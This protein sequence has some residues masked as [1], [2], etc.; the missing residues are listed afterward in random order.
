MSSS[1]II[2]AGELGA[3]S[4]WQPLSLATAEAAVPVPAV[5]EPPAEEVTPGV[6]GDMA[7][8]V[9]D[10]VAPEAAVASYP[11]A[12]EL[13]A[14]HQAAW[15]AGYDAGLAEGRRDGLAQGLE[16]GR[17]SG[18]QAAAQ[19]A[20]ARF[21]Q[22]W[23]PLDAMLQEMASGVAQLDAQLA[24]ALLALAFEC[25]QKL[26]AQ[27]LAARPEALR[28]LVA[29]ALAPLA[30]ELTQLRVRVHPDEQQLLVHFLATEYPHVAVKWQ[31]DTSLSRGGCVIDTAISHFDLSFETREAV[32]RQALGL[33][34]DG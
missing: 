21:A 5:V 26:A 33:D 14:V 25:A 10:S 12:A 8:D 23:A 11:T 16:E 29:D 30:T 17:A 28:T 22:S 20:Q 1:P 13:E 32:L 31:P 24:P 6:S 34:G 15:Q 3:W 4:P 27:Q 9:A 18:E 7:D 19:A 2:P